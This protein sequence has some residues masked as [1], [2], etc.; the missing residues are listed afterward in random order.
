MMK[1]LDGGRPVLVLQVGC[2]GRELVLRREGE[3]RRLSTQPG[4][5][6]RGSEFANTADVSFAAAQ[7][8][9]PPASPPAPEETSP[10]NQRCLFAGIK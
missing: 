2:E 6:V 10:P 9:P 5:E 1:L 8:S 7:Q 3:V 4:T